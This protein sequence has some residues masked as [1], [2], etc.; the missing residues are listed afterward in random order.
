MNT[1]TV[2]LRRLTLLAALLALSV[3]GCGLYLDLDVTLFT[4]VEL[5]EALQETVTPE[6]LPAGGGRVSV[7]YKTEIDLTEDIGDEVDGGGV[8]LVLEQLHY[9]VPENTVTTDMHNVEIVLADAGADSPVGGESLGF[10]AIIPA[11]TTVETTPLETDL[12]GEQALEERLK[13]LTF[14]VFVL[15]DVDVEPEPA[16]MPSG[17]AMIEVDVQAQVRHN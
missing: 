13:A 6:D 14:T 17:E 10:V 15:A 7:V 11:R 3:S 5:E 8:E 4:R 16:P 12:K 9:R 2:A 1:R